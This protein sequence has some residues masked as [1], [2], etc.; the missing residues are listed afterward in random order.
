[1]TAYQPPLEDMRFALAHAAGLDSLAALPGYEEATPDLVAAILD[2]AAKLAADVVAPLNRSGDREGAVLENGVVRMPSGFR[3]AY[4]LFR[5]GGWNAIPFDPDYGGQGL[6]WTVALA[7]QEMW[8]A[9][10]MAFGICPLLTQGAIELL[11]A[12]GSDD[13]RRLYLPKMVA[14]DWTG[15]MDLTESQAGSDLAQIRTRAVPANGAYRLFGQKIF[16]SYG[17]HD[18][19]DNIVHMVLARLPDAPPGT[20][21]ISLF[22]VPKHLPDADGRPGR[23]NDLRC[24]ALEHKL[25]IHASPTTVLAF[26]DDDGAVGF[27]VGPAHQGLRCMFTMMNNA[28]LAVGLQGVAIAERAYQQARAFARERVQSNDLDGH[29]PV[30]IIRHPKVRRMLLTMR[31]LAEAGRA[32]VYNAAG[33]L[34]RSRRHPDPVERKRAQTRVDLLTPVVKA[35]C[36][37][38]GVEAASLGIQVHGGMGYVEET[39]AAQHLRDAR[40]APIYEGTNDIQ[41]ADLAFRKVGRDGGAAARALIAEMRAFDAALA[42]AQD[43]DLAAIRQRLANGVAAFDRA[44]DWVAAQAAVDPAAVAAGSN[45]YLRIAGLVVGGYL[46]AQ[47]ARAAAANGTAGF[48]RAKRATARFFCD[49]LLPQTG[50]LLTTLTDGHA[51]VTAA[52]ESLS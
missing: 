22:L 27:L 17:D 50:A 30:A 21:G 52:D 29:G 11:H 39:G 42:A 33:A 51:T 25:G 10:N 45:H 1:M 5:E 34:D 36:T 7:V 3:E 38:A 37:D 6:P 48:G 43:E 4:A 32:L 24:V 16:I 49:Q 44:T 26:G 20:R 2:E 46:L 18:L 28:R 12:H 8:H 23:R 35:W 47:A 40:V 41:A 9:A 31:V 15:S 13:L 19:T 14:G